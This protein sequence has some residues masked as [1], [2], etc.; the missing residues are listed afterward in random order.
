MDVDVDSPRRLSISHV[1]LRGLEIG[2]YPRG[3]VGRGVCSARAGQ[4]K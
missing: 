2:E 3:W 1:D 4:K